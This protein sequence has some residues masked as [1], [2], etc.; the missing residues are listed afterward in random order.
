MFRG[1]PRKPPRD[2]VGRWI[3]TQDLNR[4]LAEPLPAWWWLPPVLWPTEEQDLAEIVRRILRKGGRNFVVNAPW[5]VA[6]FKIPR[7]V[8]LWAG[9]FCNIA[10]GLAVEALAEAG[11]SGVIVSPEL[12][13]DSC[14]ALPGQS[15]LPLGIVLTGNW[16]FCISRIAADAVRLN[17][18]FM[19]PKRESGW[20]SKIG[21]NFW[22]YPNWRLDLRPHKDEL[23]KAGYQVW[24][25]LM[26]EVPRT[27]FMKK[28]P[29]LWNWEIG[30]K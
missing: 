19:S 24:F 9:P 22:V 14:L 10:N 1:P 29:G 20:I 28:R 2:P 16:P 17:Q 5:Q 26:E 21:S 30:M 7:S 15:P 11:F 3:A 13:R 6:L 25:H 4:T 12:D 18:P 27:V 8:N 23:Q